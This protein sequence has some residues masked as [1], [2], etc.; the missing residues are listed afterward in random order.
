MTGPPLAQ[1]RLRFVLGKGGVG[2]STVAAAL[3]LST[4]RAGGRAL[5][6]EVAGQ[7]RLSQLFSAAAVGDETPTELRPGLF[8]ISIDAGRAT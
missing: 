7:Q 6:V 4:A 1:R 5:V 8:G 2:K 3:A